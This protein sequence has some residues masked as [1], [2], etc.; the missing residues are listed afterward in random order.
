MRSR[1]DRI[2]IQETRIDE[3]C[4]LGW[5]LKKVESN[6]SNRFGCFQVERRERER[7]RERERR[8]EKEQKRRDTHHSKWYLP[9]RCSEQQPHCATHFVEPPY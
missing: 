7:E 1:K 5:G 4:W 6:N 3:C 9:Y 8:K 2:G